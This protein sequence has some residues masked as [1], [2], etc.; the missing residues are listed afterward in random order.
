MKTRIDPN[1]LDASAKVGSTATRRESNDMVIA[2]IHEHADELDNPAIASEIDLYSVVTYGADRT[3]VDDATAA[4][5][6]ALAAAWANV[7]ATGRRSV[8]Y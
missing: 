3:G 8:V 7:Q 1:V 4:T 2:A 6:S 5:M